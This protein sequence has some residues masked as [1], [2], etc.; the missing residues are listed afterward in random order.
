MTINSDE[1]PFLAPLSNIFEER[2]TNRGVI[3][4]LA[5]LFASIFLLLFYAGLISIVPYFLI[6]VLATMVILLMQR[7]RMKADSGKITA[8]EIFNGK[9]MFEINTDFLWDIP[10]NEIKNRFAQLNESMGELAADFT[11]ITTPLDTQ[12]YG[13]SPD[14]GRIG[15]EKDITYISYLLIEDKKINLDEVIRKLSTYGVEINRVSTDNL[16]EKLQY[17]WSGVMQRGKRFISG[18]RKYSFSVISQ[19]LRRTHLQTSRLVE[20]LSFPCTT[21]TCFNKMKKSSDVIG[22]N[23][24][25][26][27]A[28]SRMKSEKNLPEGDINLMR[29]ES[30]MA[31]RHDS[32]E[33]LYNIQQSFLLSASTSYG[34]RRLQD[35]LTIMCE[36][37]GFSLTIPDHRNE[38]LLRSTFK[39]SAIMYPQTGDKLAAFFS[40]LTESDESG[41]IIGK[42]S[43]TGRQVYFDPF[44]NSSYNMLVIGET[45]SGKS[46]FSKLFLS[47]MIE[48]N[49]VK[50]VLVLDVLNEYSTSRWEL[51]SEEHKI[52]LR[53]IQVNEENIVQSMEQAMTFLRSNQTEE[54][55]I[56]V[57]EAHLFLNNITASAIFVQMVKVS[58][59]FKGCILTVSQDTSDLTTDQG[60]KVLNNSYSVFIFRNK[61]MG[62]LEKFGIKLSEFG[63]A[64][65][66]LSLQGGKNSPFSEAFFYSRHRLKKLVIS[67]RESEESLVHSS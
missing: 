38:N 34:L 45:G 39:G 64:R 47:R 67:R 8:A 62:A 31:I 4:P 11:I 21:V 54:K 23:I 19:S 27:L 16:T 60:K 1:F 25:K 61:L 33:W 10:V 32:S 6:A 50:H 29:K 7:K 65:A 49:R 51:M 63:Y 43:Q 36:S 24:S 59:H 37:W 35:Q 13:S 53:I 17:L 40:F 9:V 12:N 66:Q 2:R 18:K 14:V 3:L 52:N 28:R 44:S 46:F 56:V 55:I 30:A 20:S 15:D 57:E 41:I 48:E 5:M 22:R 58:R 42:D 26:I